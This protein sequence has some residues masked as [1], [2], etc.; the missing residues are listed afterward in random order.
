MSFKDAFLIVAAGVILHISMAAIAVLF[1]GYF[2]FT[3][4]DQ[5]LANRAR[6]KVFEDELYG[7]TTDPEDSDCEVNGGMTRL[8]VPSN[9]KIM[10]T[11]IAEVLRKIL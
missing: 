1:I 6:D 9:E 10:V 5:W 3:R 11:R 2:G 4:L 7:W 8:K